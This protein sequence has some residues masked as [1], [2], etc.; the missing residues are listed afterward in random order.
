M[1]SE[2]LRIIEIANL[3]NFYKIIEINNS[4]SNVNSYNR[5]IV[6]VLDYKI[7]PNLVLKK[8]LNQCSKIRSLKISKTGIKASLKLNE[9][10][11]IG[12]NLFNKNFDINQIATIFSDLPKAYDSNLPIKRDKLLDTQLLLKHVQI[13][14]GEK[15]Y[16]TLYSVESTE[17]SKAKSLILEFVN[18]NNM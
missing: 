5:P 9:K 7:N 2:Y 1:P 11:D 13:P 3:K 16:E 6:E 15:F 14:E 8:Q 12:I 4:T 10:C 18:K 17:S